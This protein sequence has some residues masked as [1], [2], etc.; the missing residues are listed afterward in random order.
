MKQITYGLLILFV[1]GCTEFKE[2]IQFII[3]DYKTLTPENIN[4]NLKVANIIV[5]QSEFNDMYANFNQEI[6]IQGELNL[7]KNNIHLIEKLPVEVQIKGGLSRKFPL[8][9]LGIKFKTPYNN[10]DR[11]LIDA[12]TLNFHSLDNIKAIR[13]R[14]SGNDFIFTMLKDIS[15]TQL[16]INAG[17]NLDVMYTEQTVVFVNSIFLGIMNLRT[18]SNTNGMASLYNVN[19]SQITL[20]KISA[21]GSVYKKDGN[22]DRI[23]RFITAIEN[24]DYN[25]VHKEIDIDNFIDYIIYETY[26]AN[27][28][29]PYN[30]VRFFAIGNGPFRFVLYDLDLVSSQNINEPPIA[31]INSTHENHIS[32]LFHLMYTNKSFRE[33]YES[34]YNS[35][36]NSPLLNSTN[37]NIIIDQYKENIEQLIP[38]HMQKYAIPKTLINWNL[39]IKRTKDNFKIREK[40]MNELY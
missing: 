29:W 22:F 2:D 15:Y 37:F 11:K 14:N 19:K 10:K 1:F 12:T 28:D 7:Y 13:F 25:Y 21:G 18:E 30:N 32:K 16:A 20:A 33:T 36:V 38:L 17:L 35:L 34:R 6:E 8:K 31:F 5:K 39:L 3:Q 26:I 4:T 9:S 24:K 40:Y 27:I 23:N